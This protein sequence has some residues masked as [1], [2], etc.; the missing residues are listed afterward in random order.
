MAALLEMTRQQVLEQF[1]LQPN[2]TG[3][4]EVQVS[5]LTWRITHLTEHFKAHKHDY[6]S[7]VG[8]QRLVNSRRRLLNYIKRE[9]SARYAKLLV[10]LD[11]RH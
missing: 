8:L 4:V 3:S 11:L 9:D 1:R 10:A 7:R 5:L 2:D 6:H